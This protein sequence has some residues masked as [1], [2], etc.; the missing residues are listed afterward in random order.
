MGI[1]PDFLYLVFFI[2]T[3]FY[4]M[5]EFEESEI[6]RLRKDLEA[7]RIEA[8]KYRVAYMTSPDAININRMSDGMY[9][10]VNEGFTNILGY[11]E[12]DVV[13]KT[14]LELN[15]WVNPDDRADFVKELDSKGFVKNFE[16]RFL[17][18]DG[19]IVNSKI[20]GS[21]IE[22]NGIDH[23]LS[24]SRDITIRRKAE[25]ALAKEQFLINALMSN[26]TDHVYFK[27]LESKFIRNNKAHALSFGFS[28]PDTLIGKSDFDF[29]TEQAARK[30]FE[31][32][33]TIIRTG[34]PIQKEERL[35]RKDSS[36]AWFS[37]IKMPLRDNEGNIIGTFGISRD[38]TAQKKAEEQLFLIANA[39][40]SINECVSITDMNDKVLFLNHAFLETYG[41]DENDLKE[42]SISIIRSPSN[43]PDLVNQILPAT[44]QGGWQGE[45][46]NRKKDGTEFSVFLSTA[47]VKN[48]DGQPVAMIGVA[49]DITQTKKTEAALRLSEERF[50]SLAQ[51]AN[52]AI[53]TINDS[54]I[55]LGWNRAAESIFGFS[56]S[57]IIGK[58]L[59]II[60][61]SSYLV[62]HSHSFGRLETGVDKNVIGRTRELEGL[63][64]DGII[65]PIELSV[66]RWETS[67]GK[68][69]TG[70]V[71][72]I[73]K[74]KR[75][76]L[77]NQVLYEITQGVTSTSNLDDL[78]KLIHHSLGK[79]VYAEN[80]F[81]ALY[82]NRTDLFSF[83]YFVDKIDTTPPPISMRKSCSAYV[84]RKVEPLLLTQRV[85]DHLVELG[86]VELVGS[87][88]P[89]W[90]GIPLQ[91]P[92]KVIG[93]LVLQ[94][95]EK[96]NVYSEND[97]KFLSS[98][99]GQ[100]AISIDRKRNEEEI[101]LKNE[102]LLTINAEKDKFFSI[103]AHDLRGPLSAFVA[104]T[105]IITEE[106]QVMS[107]DEIKEITESMKTSATNI[108]SLLENLLE[109]SRMKRGGLD[110]VL[111]K[112]NVKNNI[113]NCI[114]ILSESSKKKNIEVLISVPEKMEVLA[115]KHMLE[116]TIRNLV[117]NAIKFTRP[118][119]KVSIIADYTDAH[120]IEVKV[121]D[122]GIGMTAE[123]KNKLFLINE[124][125]N[126]NGTEG[127]MS[128]GLG[129]LLCK[130]FIEQCGGK[131]SVESEVDKGSTFT[132]VLP[133]Y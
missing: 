88:S 24:V 116:T 39:L 19:R 83:P 98:I 44:L 56:E 49:K 15:I 111:E 14:S 4:S 53:I 26:L 45:L 131:I 80:C 46:L 32:E 31:D 43:P 8:E 16:T 81:V 118:G 82:N 23:I 40:K 9:I 103:I 124:K 63:K 115:D 57:E 79:V 130:E 113:T 106:I 73:T 102:L 74:R 92:S 121:A 36:D 1:V 71:R 100:I 122:S 125:T 52:D 30:A 105:Q 128:T 65:F 12:T 60:V 133:E 101:T 29:F 110:F 94:H 72:E 85:F 42:E 20:Y 34:I 11:S 38:I 120:S 78:L 55:I 76:E 67:E 41:F 6:D 126:R 28:N 25:A 108:Y 58:S 114:N 17:S 37:V 47:V 48:S 123:L 117:S 5:K 35:T 95:Y 66:S 7:S 119:G 109:W 87:N 89:S 54:G 27:D 99:G 91:T 69:Y 127:E 21:K 104:A 33:Q 77:E 107:V 59:D 22:I 70:I 132:L 97:V 61:P 93:V 2:K 10:S 3:I 84:F 62:Y 90:I 50:R 64:K 68:F 13:G 86:E 51:S 112:L 18:K 129:L 75:T 96:D